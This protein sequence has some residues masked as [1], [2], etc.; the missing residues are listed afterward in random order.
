MTQEAQIFAMMGDIKGE[1]GEFRG[2]L[3]EVIHNMNNVS[4]KID[5]LATISARNHDLPDEIATLKA[6]VALLEEEKHRR[7]G[8]VNLGTMLLRSPIIAWIFAA[9]VLAWTYLKEARS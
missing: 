6:R 4:T 2:Q 5:A 9:A 8:A 7:M 1:L 3:R